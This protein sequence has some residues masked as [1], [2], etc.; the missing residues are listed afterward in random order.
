MLHACVGMIAAFF[1]DSH[2]HASVEHGTRIAIFMP[3]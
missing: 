2:A 1:G 3:S